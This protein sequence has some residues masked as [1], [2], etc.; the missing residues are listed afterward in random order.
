VTRF[1]SVVSIFGARRFASA[2]VETLTSGE[3]TRADDSYVRPPHGLPRTAGG[4]WSGDGKGCTASAAA[5]ATPENE[6]SVRPVDTVAGWVVIIR[7]SDIGDVRIV[8]VGMRTGAAAEPGHLPL[9]SRVAGQEKAGPGAAAEAEKAAAAGGGGAAVTEDDG[10][11]VGVP[12][13]G[14]FVIVGT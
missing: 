4:H 12:A 2:T 14:V 11:V 1:R 3:R 6:S 5:K 10:G 7:F 13:V 8:V 9:G